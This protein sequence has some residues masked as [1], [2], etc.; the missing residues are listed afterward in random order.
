MKM[1]LR[2]L[3]DFQRPTIFNRVE[4]SKTKIQGLSSQFKHK[5]TKGVATMD[6]L[7]ETLAI[8]IVNYFD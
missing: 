2:Q 7:K 8:C 6:R 5:E 1:K 4:R 3:L